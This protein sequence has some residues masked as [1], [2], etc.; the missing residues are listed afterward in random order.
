MKVND[1]RYVEMKEDNS[2]DM[3]QACPTNLDFWLSIKIEAESK[4]RNP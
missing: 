2:G 4:S 3:M 1:N